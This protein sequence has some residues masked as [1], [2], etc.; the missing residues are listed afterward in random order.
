MRYYFITY[1]LQLIKILKSIHNWVFIGDWDSP[2]KNSSRD[3]TLGL[4]YRRLR[5]LQ[6]KTFDMC[7]LEVLRGY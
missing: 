1:D 7:H 5:N 2:D 3:D 4:G 6:S